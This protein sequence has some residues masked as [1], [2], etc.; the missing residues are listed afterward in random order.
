M[1]R[2][3]E[4]LDI[5]RLKDSHGRISQV[6]LSQTNAR[7]TWFSSSPSISTWSWFFILTYKWPFTNTPE[8][9]RKQWLKLEIEKK[10][11]KKFL[12]HINLTP[13][14]LQ[15]SISPTPRSFHRCSLFQVLVWM[16]LELHNSTLSHWKNKA[17]TSQRLSRSPF[18]SLFFPSSSVCCLLSTLSRLLYSPV[19]CMCEE[20]CRRAMVEWVVTGWS[21]S[22]LY[23]S[24]DQYWD[25]SG[26][27]P[28]TWTGTDTPGEMSPVKTKRERLMSDW[29][30]IRKF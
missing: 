2:L 7:P 21:S 10:T 1:Q 19:L 5:S 25:M 9:K 20:H 12:F 17:Q 28:G 27:L 13:G 18:S 14:T 3:V 16:C 8:N 23:C 24:L 29:K 30:H 22:S 4:S 26:S 15:R 11:D 6:L